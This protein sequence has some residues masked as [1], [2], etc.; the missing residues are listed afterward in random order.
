MGTIPT[1]LA[2][3]RRIHAL[4]AALLGYIVSIDAREMPNLTL[5]PFSLDLIVY[6]TLCLVLI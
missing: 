2:V 4:H 5:A 6:E 3:L 1:G